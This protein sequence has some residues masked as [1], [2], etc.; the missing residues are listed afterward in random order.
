MVMVR[1]TVL[2]MAAIL[3]ILRW[4][5]KKIWVKEEERWART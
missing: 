1:V 2:I 3:V 5:Y 4:R